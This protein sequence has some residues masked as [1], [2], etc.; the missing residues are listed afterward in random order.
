[1]RAEDRDAG[2]AI[3]ASK[4]RS[5]GLDNLVGCGDSSGFALDPAGVTPSRNLAPLPAGSTAPFAPMRSG[6]RRVAAR[7]WVM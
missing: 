7:S 4:Q 6:W 2:V 5:C 1:M 3:A